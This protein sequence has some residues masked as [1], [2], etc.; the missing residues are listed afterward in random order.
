MSRRP[1]LAFV[2]AV[3]FLAVPSIVAAQSAIAGVVRDSTGAVLPGVT[4][5]VAS[6]ALIEKVRTAVTDE[7][8]QYRIVD[9]RPGTYAVTFTLSGFGAVKREGIVLEANFTAPV[10]TELRVGAVAETVTVTG[11]SPIVDVQN[12]SRREVVTRDLLDSLP[13]GRD[14]STIGN[15]L[16]SVN[17]GRFDVAGSSTAQS[18]TLVAFGSRGADFQVR[19]DG[20]S[21]NISFG[22]GWFNGMYH[23]ESVF[24]EMS[25]TVSGGSAE[26]QTGGVTVN[27][28]PR[29]G[30]N[31]FIYEA[32]GT[33][34][35][36]SLQAD[37]FDDAL[38]NRGFR[39]SSGGL[40][41]MWD[42]NGLVGGPIMRDR[43]WFFGSARYWGFAENVP[44]VFW[45]QSDPRVTPPNAQQASDDTNLK[46]FNVRLTTQLKNTRV[47][48]SYDNA[49]RWRRHFG[50]E[51]RG[52]S[53]ESFAQY[54]NDSY[55]TQFKATTT[56][57]SRMLLETGFTR[58]FWYSEL[59]PQPGT[60]LAS[61]VVAFAACPSGTDYGDIRKTDLALSWNW[62]APGN[63]NSTF[64]APRT[65]YTASVSYSTGAHDIKV[66]LTQAWGYRTIVTPMN[67][68]GLTQRYRLGVPDS[69]LLSTV[70]SVQDTSIDREIGAFIQ[71]SWTKGRLTLNPGLRLDYI[72]GSVRNQTAGAG[73]F[74]PERVF[75]QADYVTVPMFTDVSPRFGV[76]YDLFG[77]GKT[78]LKGSVG[79][80]VQSFQSN[81]AD[82][83]NP[84]GGG[85]D[86]RTW[87]D[88]NGD[89]IAQENELGVT[90]N[91]N[92]GRPASVTRPDPDL[93][94]PYQVLYN[95]GIQQELR[96]GLSASVNYYYRKYSRDFWVDNLADTIADY[97]TIVIPDP[98]AN[99]QS[100][101]VY[102]ISAAKLGVIDNYR[103]NSA[104]NGR[105]YHG[106]DVSFAARLRNG[107]Q[108]Q[109]GVNSGTLHESVCQVSDPNNLRYC[110]R[111]YPFET[112][113][114]L[115]GTYP[116]PYGFRISGLFQSVPGIQSARDA[117]NVGRD[118]AINY[119]IGRAIAPGLNQ[120]TV[121]V[122]L[123]E[124]GSLF[125]DRV[126]QLDFALSRDFRLGR[127]RVRPQVDIFNALNNNAVTQVNANWGANL[128]PVS[129]L[130]PRLVRFNVRVNF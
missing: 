128:L 33:W 119:S 62:N 2:L 122:R 44:N 3:G 107:T 99:G 66:G 120:T 65:S 76:A 17:M 47:S 124:P 22:E 31:S 102:S 101:T 45:K 41:K 72:K 89:D 61:C 21:A 53:P 113:F 96:P 127:V 74:L 24:Q 75:T 39:P 26:T 13:T 42:S 7:A 123:N 55:V 37:N 12:T 59:L 73:R 116:L 77:N 16:P 115:S 78:A 86:T 97:S 25:Y 48:G 91:R 14:Y 18:G 104:E 109:G 92:F 71:D 98:R 19:I 121:N 81:L 93:K 80:Y 51:N 23:N 68:G 114:K 130:N 100:I 30:G 10:N 43:L 129:V 40:A 54:P 27:M 108:L 60:R 94:R 79:K 38:R 56:L 9:L 1:W 106:V 112:Q 35:N 83:Y 58:V 11:E 8:G 20:M 15:T 32:L 57:S 85:T 28:I 90:T 88:L 125:L 103:R 118:V 84:M 46:A 63:P 67:N 34:S 5:E 6:P 117:G 111:P 69:V 4:I 110:D 126:N 29:S 82:D 52:G 49:P 105:A 36:N 70:P 87:R 64:E 95:A 50:I